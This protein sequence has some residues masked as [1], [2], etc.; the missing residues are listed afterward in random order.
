MAITEGIQTA[1]VSNTNLITL[2]GGTTIY[3]ALAPQEASTPYVVY[4]ISGG[5]EDNTTPKDSVDEFYT[6]YGVTSNDATLAGSISDEIRNALHEA[7]LTFGGSVW[8]HIKC[9]REQKLWLTEHAERLTFYSA[10]GIFRVRA[11]REP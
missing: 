1:L 6:V 5:G 7:E 9:N 8:K 3:Q 2:L 4:F 10:G 11:I